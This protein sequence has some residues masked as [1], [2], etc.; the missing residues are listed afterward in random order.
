MA[1]NLLNDAELTAL[2]QQVDEQLNAL[3][4]QPVAAFRG[5][6]GPG[7]LPGA[8]AQQALI[9]KATCETFET[10]WQKYKRHLRKDLCLPGGILY[11]QW[12]KWKDLQSKSAV[13]VAY[14]A[15]AGMGIP[16]ASLAPA[17]VAVTVF[18]LNVAIKVGIDTVCEGCKPEGENPDERPKKTSG[19]KSKSE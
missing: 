7:A 15:L 17:A 3:Q 9:E 10:F 13:K 6:E 12:H 1:A 8:P 5:I 4:S 18:L 16:T 14:G 19:K 2:A 11:E